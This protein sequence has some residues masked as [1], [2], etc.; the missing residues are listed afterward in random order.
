MSQKIMIEFGTKIDTA[1]TVAAA[2][3]MQAIIQ[4]SSTKGPM[5]ESAIAQLKAVNDYAKKIEAINNKPKISQ[6]DFNQLRMYTDLMNNSASKIS[7]IYS[8]AGVGLS[9]GMSKALAELEIIKK[10][11]DDTIRNIKKGYNDSHPKTS[12]DSTPEYLKNQK[13]QLKTLE[14][15]KPKA[16]QKVSDEMANE[17]INQNKIRQQG[18][19]LSKSAQDKILGDFNASN[20]TQFASYEEFISSKKRLDDEYATYSTQAKRKTVANEQAS[21]KAI[22]EMEE[23]RVNQTKID[24]DRINIIRK[25]TNLIGGAKTKAI[26]D[27]GIPGVTGVATGKDLSNNETYQKSLNILD[28]TKQYQKEIF[29]DITKQNIALGEQIKDRKVIITQ[30]EKENKIQ[31]DLLNNKLNPSQIAGKVATAEND[32][33]TKAESEIQKKQTHISTIEDAHSKTQQAVL[34][35][36]TNARNAQTA[37]TSEIEKQLTQDEKANTVETNKVAIATEAAAAEEAKRSKVLVDAGNQMDKATLKQKMFGKMTDSLG[38]TLTRVTSAFYLFYKA[39]QMVGKAVSTLTTLDDEITQIGIVTLKTGDEIWSNFSSFNKMAMDLSTTTT[40]WLKGAKTFYQQGLSTTE[41]IG[42]VAATTKIAALSEVDFAEASKTLTAAI[43][44]YNM[45][46]SQAEAVTDKLAAVGAASAADFHELS[47]AM[48]KVSASAYTA[49][50]SFDSLM[51][52]LAKGIETSREA[53][54]AYLNRELLKSVA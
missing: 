37:K 15:D 44:G 16:I 6:N 11:S 9:A 7:D 31:Q 14:A 34:I 27:L 2:K 3:Q 54:E 49:G 47:V 23:Q 5:K 52:V 45:E 35:A 32:A 24:Q 39:Q 48:E 13:D 29:D 18:I 8:K 19:D 4:N 1:Q 53:P 33:R 25:D 17:L 28:R 46:T 41:V 42:M 26:K 36:E 12:F 51:G 38:S 50:M 40:K 21:Q 20:N 43:R 10:Q 22:L 30:L